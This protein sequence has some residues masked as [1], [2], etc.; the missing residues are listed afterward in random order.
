MIFWSDLDLGSEILKPLWPLPLD[1]DRNHNT[2]SRLQ[3]KN[4]GLA[5]LHSKTFKNWTC[6]TLDSIYREHRSVLIEVISL[7][8]YYSNIPTIRSNIPAVSIP[9]IRVRPCTASHSAIRLCVSAMQLFPCVGP[10]TESQ[11]DSNTFLFRILPFY[12]KFFGLGP[13]VM[14][15]LWRQTCN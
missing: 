9:V 5:R 6:C 12:F 8:N 3:D 14:Q 11:T 4:D 15:Q 1:Q 7:R 13:S 2:W 10:A